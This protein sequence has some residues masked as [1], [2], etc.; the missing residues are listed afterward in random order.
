MARRSNSQEKIQSHQEKPRKLVGWVR[1][2]ITSTLA[3]LTILFGSWCDR[4]PRDK[5]ILN[6]EK[7]SIGF[8]IEHWNSLWSAWVD[9]IDYDIVVTKQWDT[10][11]WLI[12]QK[13][14]FN[15]KKTTIESDD[16]DKVFEEISETLDNEQIT[17]ETRSKQEK[18]IDF[19]KKEF[20]DKV[21]NN[22]NSSQ[23][24]KI[25]IKYKSE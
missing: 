22:E 24:D 21:L 18:K 8:S 13:N 15:S 2:T 20:E 5:I 6:P 10:Y 3:A 4:I 25:T 17:D 12:N 23:V 1:K 9:I 16:L 14:R 7:Q 11:M 19:V